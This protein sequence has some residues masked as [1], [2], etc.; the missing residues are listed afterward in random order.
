MKTREY[1]EHLTERLDAERL[2]YS[3]VYRFGQGP[4]IPPL[5]RKQPM[6]EIIR[7]RLIEERIERAFQRTERN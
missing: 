1:R 7:Q 5:I 6:R 3:Y 2:T 4:M